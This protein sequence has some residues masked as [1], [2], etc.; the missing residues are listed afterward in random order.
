MVMTAPGFVF[1]IIA[2][3]FCVDH[4]FSGADLFFRKTCLRPEIC[5]KKQRAKNL[6]IPHALFSYTECVMKSANQIKVKNQFTRGSKNAKGGT[7]RKIVSLACLPLLA[8]ILF[9]TPAAASPDWVEYLRS[10]DGTVFSH[11]R[12][13]NIDKRNGNHIVQVLGK[14]NL[15]DAGR[16]KYLQSL[17]ERGL[18]AEEYRRMSRK[19]FTCEIDCGKKLIRKASLIVY[20]TS[21]KVIFSGKNHSPQWEPVL[22]DSTG[23]ALRKAVCK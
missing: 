15:S 14:E 16:E 3:S 1:F 17:K 7:Y 9:A 19:M 8:F 5:G 22:P 4:S 18:P 21:G 13:L 12:K 20:D 23:D 11:H 10:E 6:L 2:D